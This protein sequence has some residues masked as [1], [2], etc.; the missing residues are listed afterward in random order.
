MITNTFSERD[1]K[2]RFLFRELDRRIKDKYDFVLKID[3][4]I[5]EE[6]FNNQTVL[7]FKLVLKHKHERLYLNQTISNMVHLMR[8]FDNS[9]EYMFQDIETKLFEYLDK[10]KK[11][12][13]IQ[14]QYEILQELLPEKKELKEKP[15]KLKI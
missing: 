6:L 7:Q 11:P 9:F 13:E 10:E 3:M 12:Y 1:T 8:S 5:M 14:N 4:E 2:L 15:K